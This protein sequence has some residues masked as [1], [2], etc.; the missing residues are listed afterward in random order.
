[1]LGRLTAS[2]L[3]PPTLLN[4]LPAAGGPMGRTCNR[5]VRLDD[6]SKDKGNAR[7]THGISLE[8][9]DL[10]ERTSCSRGTNGKDLQPTSKTR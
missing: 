5:Q 3:N 2:R 9:S 4:A 7:P 8:S 6:S 10:A 1:M